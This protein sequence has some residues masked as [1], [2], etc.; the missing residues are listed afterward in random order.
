MKYS[1]IFKILSFVTLFWHFIF[2]EEPLTSIFLVF[3]VSMV[4]GFLSA[5][6]QF[7]FAKGKYWPSWFLIEKTSLY[8]GL[9]DSLLLIKIFF[10]SEGGDPNE[11]ILEFTGI[12]SGIIFFLVSFFSFLDWSSGPISEIE[13]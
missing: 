8:S 9:I 4:F 2:S 5:F 12:L 13:D 11:F 10:Y 1:L 7:K 6:V 3:T